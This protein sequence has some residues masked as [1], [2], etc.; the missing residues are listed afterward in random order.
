MTDRQ[1]QKVSSPEILI[2]TESIENLGPLAGILGDG[3]YRV[4]AI[5]GIG[6]IES[7]E[8]DRLP[9]LILLDV[10]I[11]GANGNELLRSLKSDEKSRHIPVVLIGDPY[12]TGDDERSLETEGSDFIPGHFQSKDVLAKL[13]MHLILQSMSKKLDDQKARLEKEIDARKKIE[14]ECDQIN[15]ELQAALENAKT[16]SGYLPICAS[17]KKIRDDRGYWHQV[18]VYIREHSEAQLS[19]GICQDCANRLYPEFVTPGAATSKQKIILC[20]DDDADDRLLI[21]EAFDTMP[22]EIYFTEDG[23]D[24]LDYL[25]HQGKYSDGKIP[26]PKPDLI[27]LDLNM[28]RKDGR[29]AL[30][31]I[32]ADPMLRSIPIVILTTSQDRADVMRCYDL[33]AN[34]FITK[35]T[36]HEDLVK[37]VDTFC[38]YWTRISYLPRFFVI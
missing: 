28:P 21:K 18:E 13:N 32:K 16:L 30:Q 37:I 11:P 38:H 4:R 33:G 19:H 23:I 12:E 3:G 14:A 20:A 7:V 34:S 26:S 15:S 2:V 35:P 27:L 31:E 8:Q 6:A 25:W 17:C 5:D 1:V 22:T 36:A 24:L 9:D 10:K 29:E